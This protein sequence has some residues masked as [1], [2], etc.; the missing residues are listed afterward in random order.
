MVEAVVGAEVVEGVD[1]AG[2][3]VAGAVDEAGEAGV[4]DGAGAHG[5]GFEGDVEGAI[6][7]TPV[8]EGLP[9]LAEGD[10][11]G[12]GG[13]VVVEFAEVVSAADDLRWGVEGVMDDE[14]TDGD[15]GASGGILGELEGLAHEED[16]IEGGH[17][18]APGEAGG[19]SLQR[20]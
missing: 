14:G 18:G 7:E 6:E 4:D 5:A 3:G 13:G 1:G 11:F 10:D 9:G 19:Y 12:V 17:E 15:F 2:L 16:V 8:A 20:R